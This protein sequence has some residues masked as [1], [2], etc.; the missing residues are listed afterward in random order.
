M[1]TRPDLFLMRSSAAT[2]TE[3]TEPTAAER[4]EPT[5]A[6]RTEA[7]ATN[8]RNRATEQLSAYEIYS[9]FLRFS[10]L[11]LLVFKT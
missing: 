5:A 1:R 11:L 10:C 7:T 4:A 9:P 8:R 3:G 6:E 2:A